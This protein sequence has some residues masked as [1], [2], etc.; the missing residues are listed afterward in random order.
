MT[1]VDIK[2]GGKFVIKNILADGE[3]RRRLIDMGFIRGAEG[4][5]LREALLKDPIELQLKGYRVSV[6]R[7]EAR[8]IVVEEFNHDESPSRHAI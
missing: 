3:I 2:N 4:V 5:V 8:K 1:L 6:R 7:S